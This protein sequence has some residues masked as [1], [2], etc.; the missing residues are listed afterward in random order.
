MEQIVTAVH[1]RQ[2]KWYSSMEGA[3]HSVKGLFEDGLPS[4][5]EAVSRDLH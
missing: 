2:G 5:P 3:W 1:W 4:K